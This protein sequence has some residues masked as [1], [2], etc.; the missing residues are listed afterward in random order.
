LVERSALPPFFVLDFDG[1][2]ETSGVALRP[3]VS[4]PDSPY[5]FTL[6]HPD[7]AG[8]GRAEASRLKI[9]RG[10]L[11]TLA[12]ACA[13]GG[14]LCARVLARQRKLAEL[15]SAFVAGV[16]HDLRTPLAS[17]LLLAENLE[18]GVAG[19]ADRARYHG[20]L[21]KEATR[22][23]RLVDDVLDFSRLERGEAPRLERE[24]LD[25]GRFA[26]ELE[27]DCRARVEAEG[28][29]FTCERGSLPES[30]SLD[31][32]AVRRAL[33]NLLDNALKHGSGAVRLSLASAHGRL[34]F[35]VAD[36]GP[37]VP[38]TERE[39][40][41]EPFERLNG[42]NGHTGGTGLGLAIVRSIARA[43][44]GE[45]R[46]R[47]GEDGTGAVFELDLPLEEAP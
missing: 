9:L 31:A 27:E 28:R 25:L 42:T 39:R 19:D 20:A 38:A 16:S 22:L 4:L 12:F 11:F 7:P 41:F 35:A 2:D 17:I 26:G 29:A 10:A 3:R 46:V 14:F 8:L 37:G 15:K 47:A 24:G 40:V 6:R 13:A 5:A 21:R 30:A 36:E 43:H 18:T 33:E 34:V 1:T 23:R 32:H 45:A 44:G